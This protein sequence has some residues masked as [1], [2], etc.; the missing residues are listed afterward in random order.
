MVTLAPKRPGVQ[1]SLALLD[2]LAPL[3]NSSLG[4]SLPKTT[5]QLELIYYQLFLSKAHGLFATLFAII[6][7]GNIAH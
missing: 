3:D 2:N 5:K 7:D 6:L 1:I 4:M